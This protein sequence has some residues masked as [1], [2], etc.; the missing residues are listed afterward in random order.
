MC[1]KNNPNRIKDKHAQIVWVANRLNE[2]GQWRLPRVCVCVRAFLCVGFEILFF[3]HSIDRRTCSLASHT[4]IL[5]AESRIALGCTVTNFNGHITHLLSSKITS[6]N[7]FHVL[8]STNNDT[9]I[10][11]SK[12][13]V[14]KIQ[15]LDLIHLWNGVK[16]SASIWA[17]IIKRIC[18]DFPP[19]T[20]PIQL[21]VTMK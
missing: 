1:F 3:L 5:C 11:V 17:I 8:C 10:V 21:V 4:H 18:W 14:H 13:R 19:L 12:W 20:T 7:I 2:S 16:F 15:V 6:D 9:V